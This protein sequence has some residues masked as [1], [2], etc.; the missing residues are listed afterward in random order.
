MPEQDIRQQKK[1]GIFRA[2]LEAY[3]RYGI[4]RTTAKQ[5]A[6]IAKI[7]K[8]TIF[9]YFATTK[10][11][12]DEAFQWYISEANGHWNALHSLSEADP[13]KA[14][15]AYLKSLTELIVNDPEK[16]LLISQYVTAILATDSGF[17]EVKRQYAKKIQPFSD[18]L[19]SEFNFLAEMGIQKGVFKPK[20]MNAKD[21]ALL[22]NAIVREM[23]AQAFVQDPLGITKTCAQLE[24]IAFSL[25]GADHN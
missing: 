17:D 4:H 24:R 8:S 1:E 20:G 21:C 10:Q 19:L 6:Q 16:L 2:A 11:L 9:E 7:G 13:A 22:I 25:L 18:L 12:M 5:I 23:Q 3:A 14:L 15:S